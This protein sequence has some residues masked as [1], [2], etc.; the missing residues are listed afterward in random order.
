MALSIAVTLTNFDPF[1]VLPDKRR[2][3]ASLQRHFDPHWLLDG[4]FVLLKSGISFQIECWSRAH[5]LWKLQGYAHVRRTRL[6]PRKSWL[7]HGRITPPGNRSPKL[8]HL[9][10]ILLRAFVKITYT[11]LQRNRICFRI[12]AESTTHQQKTATYQP[13]RNAHG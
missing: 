4:I 13:S 7:L 1:L 10:C 3:K 11:Y 5:I 6:L 9:T 12:G 2:V 8:D